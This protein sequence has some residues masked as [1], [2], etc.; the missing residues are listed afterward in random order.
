MATSEAAMGKIRM[1]A[2]AEKPIPGNWAVTSD[3]LPTTDA[4]QA[5]AGM[6]LPAGGAKGFGLAFVIDLMCGLLSGGATGEEVRPLYGDP[7]IP[8]DCSHLFIAIDVAHFDMVEGFR[9][10][11]KAAAERVR[12]SRRADGVQA[13][14]APGEPEWRRGESADGQVD[15]ALEVAAMLVGLARELNV[16][17]EPIAWLLAQTKGSGHAQT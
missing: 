2:K 6:L 9:M 3:G 4:A 14:F 1:A 12:A 8:Y 7:S 13:V 15:L 16:S 5:I 11:A 10:K 17:S